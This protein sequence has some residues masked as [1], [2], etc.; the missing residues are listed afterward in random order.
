MLTMRRQKR[1]QSME[2]DKGANGTTE[3]RYK[4]EC[5]EAAKAIAD[6][7]KAEGTTHKHL[8]SALLLWFDRQPPEIQYSILH[9]KLGTD[10]K[11]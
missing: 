5:T 4:L 6:R 7:W 11:D 8:T 9:Q 1:D 3:S 10:V 2:T